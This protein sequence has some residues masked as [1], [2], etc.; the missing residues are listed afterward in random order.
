MVAN[1]PAQQ[2]VKLCV[3]PAAEPA[4]QKAEDGSTRNFELFTTD[5]QCPPCPSVIIGMSIVGLEGVLG[6]LTLVC[7][8][9]CIGLVFVD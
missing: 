9:F 4:W 5:L 3:A 6:E 2:L 8:L 7:T 1:P